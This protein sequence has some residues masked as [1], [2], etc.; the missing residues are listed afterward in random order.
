MHHEEEFPLPPFAF[1]W[2]GLTTFESR[3]LL[4]QNVPDRNLFKFLKTKPGKVQ[5]FQACMAE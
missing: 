3:I 2:P 5:K 1:H 4:S